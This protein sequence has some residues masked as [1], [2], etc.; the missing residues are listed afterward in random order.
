[1][2]DT[3]IVSNHNVSQARKKSKD[4]EDYWTLKELNK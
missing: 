1:M 4:R 2:N 3:G